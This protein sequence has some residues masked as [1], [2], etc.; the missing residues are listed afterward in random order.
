M[1]FS[2]DTLRLE[3]AMATDVG[4]IRQRNEDEV[5]I[6]PDAGVA[7]LADGMGGHQAGDVASRLAVEVL[8]EEVRNDDRVDEETLA[9]WIRAANEAIRGVAGTHSGYRGMGATIVVA[10]CQDDLVLFGYVGDSRLYRLWNSTLHQLTEDHTLVQQYINEGMISSAE[11]KTWAGRNLL[12]RGLGIEETV[13]PTFGQASLRAGQTYLLCSDGLTDPLDDDQIAEILGNPDFNAQDAADEL[14]LS[15]NS[16][17]G[18]DNVSV[19][20]IRVH[21]KTG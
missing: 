16:H 9:T 3:M 11:G 8:L 19:V 7:V 12:T 13:Q 6:L 15:A 17:G 4:R 14:V 18:P 5:R 10:V 1:R 20:V 2:H 21:E